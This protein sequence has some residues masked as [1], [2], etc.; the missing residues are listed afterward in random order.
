M[1]NRFL[2][3]TL[4]ASSMC[5]AGCSEDNSSFETPNTSDTP[6]NSGTVSQNNFTILAE[7]LE[8]Q[9]FADP[10]SNV[11]TYTELTITVRIGDRKN[12]RLTDEHTVFFKTEWGLIDP[13][14]VTED[15]FCTVKWSTSSG[16]E[17][18]TDHKNTIMA[19]TLGEESFTDV[20]G[21]AIFDDND[22]ATPSFE[23]IEEPF[24][25]S[26]RNG[27]HDSGE[28]IVDVVNGNDPTAPTNG[29]HDIGDTFF[30]GEGC[31]H[32]SL[33]SINHKSIY[34]WDDVQLL[35]DGPPTTP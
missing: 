20:N 14:C 34:V 7:N 19:Y 18:P 24:V 27:I 35:M 5:L 15:G 33:C 22:N 23:D 2:A 12:Q 6:I 16:S 32:S 28:Q 1:N 13:S 10:A 29:L 3:I 26:N 17:A 21:N 4:L 11:F 9:I 8:P 25:D 31:T 30:N